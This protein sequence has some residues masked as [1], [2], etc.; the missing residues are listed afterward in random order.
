MESP[1]ALVVL[2]TAAGDEEAE[3]IARALLDRR[4][5][6]CANVI[7]HLHSLF[8]WNNQLQQADES[9]L[10]MKTTPDALEELTAVVKLHHSYE[11]PEIIA[12]P[13]VGGSHGYLSWLSS[14]VRPPADV[15]RTAKPD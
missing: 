14:E 1:Q 13:V 9:L 15:N 10:I 2:V 12:L 5:I 6:A 11:V 7:P 8:R 3:R 4:L